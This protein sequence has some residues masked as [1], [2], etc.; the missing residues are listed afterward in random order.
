[1]VLLKT[2]SSIMVMASA[3]MSIKTLDP[4]SFTL[5]AHFGQWDSYITALDAALPNMKVTDVLKDANHPAPNAGLRGGYTK[6]FKWDKQAG[7]DDQGTSKWYPQGITTSS[8]AYEAGTY[9][10]YDVILAS[11]YSKEKTNKGVRISFINNKTRKYRNVLL[12]IPKA[13][14][15][16]APVKVHAGGIMWYGNYLY[17][18][19]TGVGIRVFDLNK[20]YRVGSGNGIGKVGSGYQAYGYKYVIPQVGYY[21]EKSATAKSFNYS[22]ISLDRTA[23]PDAVVIGQY[24]VDGPKNRIVR[25]DIDYKTRKLVASGNTV[26]ATKFYQIGLPSMQGAV[27]ITTG[28]KSKYFFTRSHGENT[29]GD[30]YTWTEGQSAVKQHKGVMSKGPEDLSYRSDKKEIWSLG[31]HPDHRVVYAVNPAKY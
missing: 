30:L 13:G 11:W 4:K 3:V 6:A 19:D 15:T 21:Y 26:T 27:S 20:I 17:V 16:F 2:F 29:Y 9:E 28:G 23:S 31:E 25:F 18:V 14:A 10:G 7:Y 1:M 8:D 5:T 22:F 24:D 12:V